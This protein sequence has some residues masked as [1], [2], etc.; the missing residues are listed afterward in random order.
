[1]RLR[2]YF[3]SIPV[4]LMF[5]VYRV[6]C[7]ILLWMKKVRLENI[8]T[9]LTLMR[10]MWI[11]FFYNAVFFITQVFGKHLLMVALIIEQLLRMFCLY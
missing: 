11:W 5:L 1:M 4:Q 7:C 2:I 9:M 10:A 3:Y 8:G 6:F